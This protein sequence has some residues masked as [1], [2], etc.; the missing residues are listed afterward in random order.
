MTDAVEWRRIYDKPTAFVGGFE[1][2]DCYRS[3]GATEGDIWRVRLWNEHRPEY[4]RLRYV[5]VP[6][7]LEGDDAENFVMQALVLLLQGAKRSEGE[8]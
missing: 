3:N 8:P 6:E 5:K 1:V 4:R 7:G 2:G